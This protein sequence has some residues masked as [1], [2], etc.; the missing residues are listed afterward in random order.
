MGGICSGTP[1][2][3][4]NKEVKSKKEKEMELK[5]KAL[6]EAKESNNINVPSLRR[7]SN[8]RIT[9]LSILYLK[10]NCE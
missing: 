7:T 10:Y 8:P 5:R 3:K 1:V 2:N 6:E 4:K 9:P